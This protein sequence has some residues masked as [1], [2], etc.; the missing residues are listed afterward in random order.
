MS[1]EK[2]AAANPRLDRLASRAR[3]TI[4]WERLWPAL[5]GLLS[6]A[7]LFLTVSWL[8]L[9][10][11]LPPQGRLIGVALFAVAVLVILVGAVRLARPTREE[12]LARLDRDSGLPHRPASGLNDR[13]AN[14]RDDPTTQ[15]LWQLH[16]RRLGEA[17]RRLKLAAPSPRMVE[18]DRYALRAAALVAVVASAFIAGPEKYARVAAAVDWRSDGAPAKG[19]RIDAWID[20]PAY[21]GKPPILLPARTGAGSDAGGPAQAQKVQAPVGSTVVVRT[22]GDS[23][24]KVEAEGGLVAPPAP[25]SGERADAVTAAQT[26]APS[27]PLPKPQTA[28]QASDR[29]FRW[30]LKGDARLIL[31]RG[32]QPL[33]AFDIG[34]IPDRP[35]TITLTEPPTSNIRGS[36]TLSY[37]INDDYG[38]NSAEATFAKPILGGKPVTGRSLVDPP[39]LALTLPPTPGGLGDGQTIADL[40]EHPWA[41]A[42]VTMTLTAH[43]GGGNE[44]KS[45]PV[46][47]TLPQRPF[48]KPLAKALVEQRRNLVLAPDDRGHVAAALDGLMI[49]PERFTPEPS[50]YLGLYTAD[51]RLKGAKDDDDLRAVADL[52]WQMAL[53]IEDGDLSD[54]ERSL[55]AAEQRLREALDRGAS[56]QEIRKLTQEL[57]EALDKFLAEMAQRAQ[58]NSK[59]DRL[60][61]PGRWVSEKDLKS[62]LDRLDEMARSGDLADA[63]QML[64]QLQSLLENLKTARPDGDGDPMGREMEQSLNDLDQMMREQQQLRDDTFQNGKQRKRQRNAKRQPSQPGQQGMQGQQGPED[65]A[66]DGEQGD[67]NADNRS[68]QDGMKGLEGRQEELRKRLDE[69]R[70]RMKQF[71]MKSEQGLDDAEGA[72]GDAEQSLGKG[73][74]GGAVDAQGRALD[75]LRRGTQ[76]LAQQMQQNGQNGEANGEDDTEGQGNPRGNRQYRRDPLDRPSQYSRDVLRG[77]ILNGGPGAAQR[78]QQVLEELRK[79]LSDPARPQEEL[80]YLERLLRRD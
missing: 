76:G 50:I 78:A 58:R 32:D 14:A 8:G 4:G 63:Q 28:S 34:S 54:A 24:V 40:S 16:R 11:E 71:G 56:D 35:P 74:R 67:D 15:A 73:D 20:P 2:P 17:A 10:L 19:F 79:R 39:R 52:L 21:T 26:T 22:S 57:R 30:E 61:R 75:A 62:M 53:Q 42:R 51:V 13:L 45:E 37:K 47:L 49:A 59:A 25:K 77:G 44:G 72:M 7:G 23:E 6:L 31:R 3:L 64:D 68:D 66:D 60:Q 9:W 69:L 27:Q 41:G 55:R 43:D 80:D 12:G 65:Q 29:E 38:V 70:R 5:V 48:V 33:A 18:R 36:L 46:E 1:E